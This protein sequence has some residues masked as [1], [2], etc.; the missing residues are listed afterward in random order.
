MT[1][2]PAVAQARHIAVVGGGWAG[3]SAAIE[4]TRRGQHVTVFEMAGQL[5]GRARRVEV[6]GTVL[7]NGQ[8]ILIGAYTATL[9]LMRLLDIAAHEVL[10]R[11]PLR[12]ISPDGTGLTLK[13]GPPVTALIRAVLGH[14]AWGWREKISLLR[15]AARWSRRGFVCDAP[16]SVAQLCTS[17]SAR[18]R[19]QL[20]DPL[21]VAALNTPADA[22][23][24]AVFLRV[25]KDA[26]FSSPGSA[27]LLLPR[28]SLSD[29]LPA[30]AARWLERA[31]AAI[32][33]SQRVEQLQSAHGDWLVNGLRFD[34]VIL[35]VTAVEAARLVATL[36]PEWS[37]QAAALRYEPIITVYARSDD[38]RLPHPMVALASGTDGERDPAQFVFDL[39]ALNGDAGLL[40]FV[41]SGASRWVDRGMDATVEAT[42]GQGR[43]E[44]ANLLH[45]PLLP[46]RA[47]TEKRATFA[48]TPGLDRPPAV[49]CQGLVAAGDYV[50]GPYPATLEGAVRSGLN[51][52]RALAA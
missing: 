16:L 36:R 47:L 29:L 35:A 34:A 6:D 5:G 15:V 28:R 4:A 48:C 25:L 19:A 22:A 21:C 17:L 33:L 8:H 49:I 13:S 23:S 46:L 1:D 26:M 39:G 24:A 52:A 41:I 40:A 27:D 3:L 10:L 32:R 44:L 20:I 43:R 42:L 37:A 45:S 30:P 18:V 7:D 2:E 50:D 9:D 51:A 11:T 14:R 31:G 12:L 38:V